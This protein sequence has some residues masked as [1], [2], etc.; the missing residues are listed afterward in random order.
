MAR[1]EAVFV[2][3]RIM[4]EFPSRVEKGEYS[5]ILYNS[6]GRA[7]GGVKGG[8]TDWEVFN[9]DHPFDSKRPWLGLGM[10]KIPGPFSQDATSGQAFVHPRSYLEEV[11][12]GNVEG[13]TI[14]SG[15]N[16]MGYVR[17]TEW[18]EKD[19]AS[20]PPENFWSEQER[21]RKMSE[22]QDRMMVIAGCAAMI[23]HYCSP[24]IPPKSKGGFL[25]LFR[26]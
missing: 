24:K 18:T 5:A 8:F 21:D 17:L 1:Y 23:L 9:L 22:A 12:L 13:S 6:S 15:G 11:L 2:D 4:I 16:D 25:D 10:V 20:F 7:F 14:F 3:E 26:R 19:G